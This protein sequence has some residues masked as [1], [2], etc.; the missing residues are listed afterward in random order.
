[1]VI[2]A[3]LDSKKISS[4]NKEA[5]ELSSKQKFGEK[6]NEKVFYML[7]EAYYLV[8]QKKMKILSSNLKKLDK[9]TVYK[10]FSRIDKDFLLN[11]FVFRDLRKKGYIVKSGLKF[12]VRFRIYDKGKNLERTHSKWL[13]FIVKEN[14]KISWYDFASKNR[15]SNSTKKSLLI[16]VVDLENDITYYESNWKKIM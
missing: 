16:C 10:K 1:M 3:I 11:Y 2:N 8:E 12:G 9:E 15:V 13:C 4:N 5:I 7:E 14:D 6:D